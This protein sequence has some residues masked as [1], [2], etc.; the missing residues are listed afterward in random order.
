MTYLA[1]CKSYNKNNGPEFWVSQEAKFRLLAPLAQDLLCVPS[2]SVV[3]RTGFLSVW[4]FDEWE[5]E[6]ADEEAREPGIS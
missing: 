5:E 4:G 2:F 3:C 1:G 6:P